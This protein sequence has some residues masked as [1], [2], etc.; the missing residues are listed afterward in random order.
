MGVLAIAHKINQM[1]YCLRA[2]AH[3]SS[4]RER[5]VQSQAR[6]LTEGGEQKTGVR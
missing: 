1:A 2:N 4:N 3:D 5:K 6:I